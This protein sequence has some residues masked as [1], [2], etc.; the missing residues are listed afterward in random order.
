TY[1]R[2]IYANPV[3][4]EYE[5]TLIAPDLDLA[6]FLKD[7]LP[8]NRIKFIKTEDNNKSIVREVKKAVRSQPY[9]LIHSHGFSAGALTVI[10]TLLKSTSCHIMTAHDVYRDELFEGTK[11]RLKLLGLNPLYS[12]LDAVLTVGADCF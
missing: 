12:R 6:D 4:A 3:F 5:L 11:G 2:Y 10:A 7:Y 8:E 9:D 1:I